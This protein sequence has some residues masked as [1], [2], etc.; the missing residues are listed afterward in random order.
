MCSVAGSYSPIEPK[1]SWT[2]SHPAH[3]SHDEGQAHVVHTRARS[4]VG[5]KPVT[6]AGPSLA[7][8]TTQGD[9]KTTNGEAL[10]ATTHSPT[11]LDHGSL[12]CSRRKLNRSWSSRRRADAQQAGP[13]HTLNTGCICLSAAET[14]LRQDNHLAPPRGR[15]GLSTLSP[16]EAGGSSRRRPVRCHK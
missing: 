6:F 3:M 9:R 2:C 8:P 12:A 11:S 5:P 14:V 16:T 1:P 7:L 4:S 10:L 15:A 13:P